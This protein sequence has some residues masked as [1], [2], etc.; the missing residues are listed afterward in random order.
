MAENRT[1]DPAPTPPVG[2]TSVNYNTDKAYG[3]SG[4]F[5]PG[6][7]FKPFVLTDWLEQGHSLSE[8]VDATAKVRKKSTFQA[9]CLGPHPFSDAGVP[10]KPTNVDGAGSGLMTVL[11]ATANSVNTAFV[12]IGNQLDLCDIRDVAE[13]LGFHRAD[14]APT[15]V[16]PAMILG[17][18]EVAPLTMAA[19]DATFAAN[20]T[21][22]T[23]IAITKVTDTTGKELPIPAAGCH[24]VLEPRI[25]SAVE[26]AMSKVLSEG[27]AK[28]SALAGGRVAAGK[29]GTSNN[30]VAL[31][32][33]GFTPQLATA[34]V[35]TKPEGGMPLQ[36][37][38]I[39]GKFQRFWYGADLAAP[40][41]KRYMDQAL[42]GQPN[43][44][45][46]AP[47]NNELYGQQVPVPDVTGQSIDSAKAQLTTAGFRVT[48]SATGAFSP[49]APT[50][51]VAGT[52][53]ASGT[54]TAKGGIV[55]IIPSNGPDPSLPGQQP[56]N[57]G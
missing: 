32:F 2:S 5:Q 31:W 14:G 45:F 57:P 10:W 30:N 35:V 3:G 8:V 20:G 42:A 7:A 43:L 29:T 33:T 56:G 24:Q 39:N 48:V 28:K 37:V 17:S 36:R 40:T 19:A 26:F 18:N 55:T 46:P 4:G 6:S 1:F 9:K 49:T 54:S 47:G 11:K 25:T 53:P 51:T 22:C 50:G 44:T 13:S 34:V 16:V 21:F 15:D 23:P 12:D 38:T 27:T 52:T 41:W